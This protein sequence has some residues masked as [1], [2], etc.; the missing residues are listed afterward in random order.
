MT[1]IAVTIVDDQH[2]VR[3]G[4]RMLCESA[5]DMRVVGEAADGRAAVET[6]RREPPDVVLMDLHMPVA[7][8]TW[9]TSEI[10]RAHR[11]V[12]VLV[13]TTFDD[14]DH[15]YAAIAAGASGFLAKDVRPQR[16]LD[17]IR[18]VADDEPVF[19][20]SVLRKLVQDAVAGRP[21]RIPLPALTPREREVLELVADGRSNAE[22]ASALTIGITTV[23]THVANLAM[24]TGADNRIRLALLGAGLSR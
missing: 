13:L 6:I 20:P 10:V 5:P 19:S 11:H 2:V 15:L 18:Q 21:T 4:L 9:A 12:K 16:L 14:D 7:D 24:K 1:A 23:K 3:T 17:A 8:G 22:I